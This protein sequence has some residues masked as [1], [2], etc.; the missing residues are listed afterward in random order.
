MSALKQ[1]LF[2]IRRADNAD[3]LDRKLTQVNADI[4][5][6]PAQKWECWDAISARLEALRH[7]DTPFAHE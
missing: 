5:L 6:S 3:L 2:V 1:H 7:I 4:D